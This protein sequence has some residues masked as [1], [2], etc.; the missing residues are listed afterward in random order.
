MADKGFDFKELSESKLAIY[1]KQY[2]KPA[3]VKK[4]KGA[5]IML[6]Y[7][8]AGKKIPCVMV[9]FK[10]PAEAAKAFKELKKNKEHLLKKTGL[11]KITIAKGADGNPEITVDIKKGGLSPG[12]L[13]AKG[14]DLFDNTLKMKLIVIGGAEEGTEENE[15]ETT[16]DADATGKEGTKE[17]APANDEKK[18]NRSA[19]IQKMKDNVGKMDKAVGSAPKEKLN[20]NV[21]KYETALTQ[22]IKEANADGEVD[23]EEQAE[24]DELKTALDA[25]KANI[26][27]GDG[28]A[29]AKKMTP[30][31]K[32][33]IKENMDKIN[34]R[35]QAITKKLGL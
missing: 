29:K 24:I 7:R 16:A 3:I 10:K 30:E 34:A 13:K 6:D 33:K 35:L 27:K 23:R 21:E 32:A 20:A 26:E 22:L 12:A 8:L 11:C 25:L 4:A 15:E 17:D 9:T 1:K 2:C 31:R 14:A 5:I 19:K 28:D 18:A